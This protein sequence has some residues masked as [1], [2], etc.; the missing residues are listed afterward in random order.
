MCTAEAQILWKLTMC[1]IFTEEENPTGQNGDMWSPK[2]LCT[3]Y[4][5]LLVERNPFTSP[6]KD[7]FLVLNNLKSKL[8]PPALQCALAKEYSC[9]CET[10]IL[11][12]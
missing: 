11:E 8:P 9:K 5:S 7:C 4:R 2:R 3:E 10:F 12:D 1:A 6:V